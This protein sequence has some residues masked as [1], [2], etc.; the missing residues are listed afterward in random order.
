MISMKAKLMRGLPGSGKST[1]SAEIMKEGGNWVRVNKDLLRTM[2]HCDVFTGKNEDVTN[3]VAKAVAKS[4][5]EQGKNVIIDDTNLNPRTLAAWDLFFKELG[6]ESEVVDMD[7]P[8]GECLARDAMREKKV[9]KDVIIKMALQYKDFLKGEKFVICDLD[10]TLCNIEHRLKYARGEQKDWGKFFAG[11]PE[12]TL[13]QDVVD[14][15][16][17][18]SLEHGARILYVSARPEKYRKDTEDWFEKNGVVGHYLLIM[19]PD[20]DTR[21]DTVVKKEIYDKYL[22]NLDIV[23]VFDDRPKVIAMWRSLGLDVIDV[24][25]GI[26]F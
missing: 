14:Q 26:P 7:T 25:D 23:K 17:N 9:G 5:I 6:I 22:K 2:L 18:T 11:I 19:R 1:K 20:N 8:I 24:G 13:R 10:G 21:D 3:N 16:V 15:L 4:A 12:D